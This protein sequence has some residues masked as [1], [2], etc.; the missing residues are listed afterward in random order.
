M[1]PLVLDLAADRIAIAVTCRVMGFRQRAF[2]RSR[3]DPVPQRDWD[4]AHLTNAVIDLHRD[5]PGF[6][7]RFIAGEAGLKASERR[8]WRLC[9]EQRLWSLHPKNRGLNKK[10]GPPV[11]DDL[12]LRDFTAI[13]LNQPWPSDITEHWT[14]EGKR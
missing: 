2:F 8:T 5:D 7:Y 12:V 1:L 3:A 11:P 4:N 6:G 13:Q 10:A 9:S 14:D